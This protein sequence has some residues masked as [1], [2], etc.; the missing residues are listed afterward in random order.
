VRPSG[1]VAVGGAALAILAVIISGCMRDIQIKT[2]QVVMAEVDPRQPA[3]AP[4]AGPG[5]PPRL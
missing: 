2:W 3:D 1:L 5:W 4:E